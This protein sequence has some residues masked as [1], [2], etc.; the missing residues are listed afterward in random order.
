MDQVIPA[1]RSA[2]RWRVW[3]A[4]VRGADVK[5]TWRSR[6]LA[7]IA[8]LLL[9]VRYLAP[10]RIW[11]GL[12]VIALGTLAVSAWWMLQLAR[13][14]D[15]RRELRAAWMQVGGLVEEKF[16][17]INKAR[18]PALWVEVVDHSDIPGYSASAI[19]AARARETVRWNIR[20]FCSLR[21]EYALGPWEVRFGDPFGLF[22]ASLTFAAGENI[23]IYPPVVRWPPPTLPWG[24]APGQAGVRALTRQP[25]GITRSVREYLPGDP[26][27][28]IHWP[29]T[30]RHSKLHVREFNQETGEDVWL[31]LDLNPE[32]HS[33]E[34]K[35]STLEI[36]VVLTA[37]LAFHLLETNRRVGLLAYG[38]EQCLLRPAVSRENLWRILRALAMAYPAGEQPLAQVLLE[39]NRI[40]PAGSTLVVVTPSVDQGWISALASLQRRGTAVHALLL[41]SGDDRPAADVQ[42]TLAGLGVSVDFV[43]V[44]APLPERPA[45]ARL[46][47]WESRILHRKGAAAADTAV[48]GGGR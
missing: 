7:P 34:G 43:D 4:S 30:A 27:G 37:S 36:G 14:M 31:L 22:Q 33:G 26:F 28:H 8:V 38:K 46:G 11:T 17:L 18:V 42:S 1:E 40:L 9:V 13:W 24:T 45:A 25:A 15:V 41:K 16:T 29:A 6:A 19:R 3:R 47:R 12:L 5:L 2:R 23:L 44:L 21:G 20:G 48:T 35:H 32:P 39:A 10:S